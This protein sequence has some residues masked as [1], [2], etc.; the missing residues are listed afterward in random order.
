MDKF[1]GY[2]DRSI[3]EVERF[4]NIGWTRRLYH[5]R[6]TIAKAITYSQH[7]EVHRTGEYVR[8]PQEWTVV[9]PNRAYADLAFEDKW[10]KQDPLAVDVTSMPVC[11]EINKARVN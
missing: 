9:A 10:R 7:N 6:F 5:F 4:G 2:L 1:N 3:D 11:G 8:E